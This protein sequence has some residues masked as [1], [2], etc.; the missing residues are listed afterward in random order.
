MR[1]GRFQGPFFKLMLSC[2]LICVSLGDRALAR[3][4]SARPLDG[5]FSDWTGIF[6]TGRV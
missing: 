6:T 5:L 2:T 4:P 1:T 3:R